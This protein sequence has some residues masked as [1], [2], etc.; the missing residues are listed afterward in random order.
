MAQP[1]T[2]ARSTATAAV[3]P[4]EGGIPGARNESPWDWRGCG[5]AVED[6]RKVLVHLDNPKAIA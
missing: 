4:D 5:D 6:R 2:T 3:L 1:Y